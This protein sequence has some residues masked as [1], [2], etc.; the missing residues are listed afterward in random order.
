MDKYLILTR[1]KYLILIGDKC[2]IPIETNA[3]FSS[4]QMPYSCTE[5]CAI[6]VG[7]RYKYCAFDSYFCMTLHA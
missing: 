6:L 5:K 4:R 7:G 1:D 3:L 2:F